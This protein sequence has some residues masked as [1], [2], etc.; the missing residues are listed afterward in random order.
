MEDKFL[1]AKTLLLC[2]PHLEDLYDALTDSAEECVRSGFYAIYP[3]EQ[4]R[5]YERIVAYEDRKVGVYNMKYLIERCFREGASPVLALVKERFIHKTPVGE[6]SKKYGVI[7]RTCYRYIKRGIVAF[8]QKLEELGFDKK[9]L[10]TE[11]GNE[12][13]FQTML[14]RVIKEDDEENGAESGA[15]NQSKGEAQ[16]KCPQITHLWASCGVRIAPRG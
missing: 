8:T 9:R 3:N 7:S 15:T 1:V 12:P 6:I 11:F 14:T 4:M 16:A 10:L 13:L 5:L 2:Y